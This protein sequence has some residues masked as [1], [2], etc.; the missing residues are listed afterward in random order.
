LSEGPLASP[1]PP[2]P[3]PRTGARGVPR[4]W[5]LTARAGQERADMSQA[6]QTSPGRLALRQ[7]E[8]VDVADRHMHA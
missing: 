6:E 1:P 2:T 7:L 4:H 8:Q 3:L 5:L